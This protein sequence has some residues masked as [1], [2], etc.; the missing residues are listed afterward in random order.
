MAVSEPAM[1][2]HPITTQQTLLDRIQIEDL[3]SSYYYNLGHGDPKV[4]AEYYTDDFVFDVNGKTYRGF[5]GLQQAYHAEERSAPYP[6]ARGVYHMLMSNPLIEVQGETATARFIWT[7][8]QSDSVKGPPR[9]V[10]QGREYDV[11]VK[12]N[13]EWVIR[14]R[15]I[16]SDAG[17]EDE[18]NAIY[19]PRADYD[20]LK[21]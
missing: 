1:A 13:G 11:L 2:R 16:I 6:A 4:Y 20:P 18:F 12:R 8:F 15:T 5:A 17:L 3:M 14:K 9:P 19:Q 10:Q 21:D 7:G